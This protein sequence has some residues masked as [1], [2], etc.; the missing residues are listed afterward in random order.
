MPSLLLVAWPS[1]G[2]PIPWGRVQPAAL[3]HSSASRTTSS[4]WLLLFILIIPLAVGVGVGFARAVLDRWRI[5]ISSLLFA[6]HAMP[7]L[8]CGAHRPCVGS[9]DLGV[10]GA[11]SSWLATSLLCPTGCSVPACPI[12]LLSGGGRLGCIADSL[13]VDRC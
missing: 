3:F 8:C 10:W 11:S 7:L 9:V 4:F 2:W 5:V 12:H 6:D 13:G 1:L